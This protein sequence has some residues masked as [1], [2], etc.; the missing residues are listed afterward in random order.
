MNKMK[1]QPLAVGETKG[2]M[3]PHGYFDFHLF[4]LRFLKLEIIFAEFISRM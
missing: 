2:V 3:K 4:K 1:N